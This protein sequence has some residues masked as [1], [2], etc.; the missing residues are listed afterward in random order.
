MPPDHETTTQDLV[1]GSVAAPALTTALVSVNA[2]ARAAD[3]L[4]LLY[5]FLR[6]QVDD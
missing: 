2:V 6:E 4:H 1:A 5:G 3:Y